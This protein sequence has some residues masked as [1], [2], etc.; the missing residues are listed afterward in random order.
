ML[1]LSYKNSQAELDGAKIKKSEN[2]EIIFLE[3]KKNIK[4]LFLNTFRI[5]SLA[6]KFKPDVVHFQE[7]PHEY[8][9]AAIILLRKLPIVLTVHDPVPHIGEDT[10]SHNSFWRRKDFYSK[11]QRKLA[12]ALISH[13]E[14]LCDQLKSATQGQKKICNIHHGPLGLLFDEVDQP[15]K[16]D[17]F[18]F[19]FFGR[20]QKYKGIELFTKA[21][22]LLKSED[23]N[24]KGVLAGR[25]PELTKI[26]NSIATKPHFI[27][28]DYFLSPKEVA[29]TFDE[30]DVVVLPYIEG[31]QSGVAA[32]AIGRGKPCIISGVGS[33]PE[34][35]VDRQTGIIIKPN[36]IDELVDAM[37]LLYNERKKCIEMGL[38][39]KQLGESEKS[40]IAAAEKT[41]KLY[42]SIINAKN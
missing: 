30:S 3:H 16:F 15:Q 7:V 14:F 40:W 10:Q 22:E 33:L 1:V 39:A 5:Y 34:M 21:I 28:K 9:T 11:L 13:G 23:L 38:K 32:L 35:V 6:R 18:N 37:R 29:T 12:G 17:T 25:G 41:A 36:N 8:Q 4:T 42:E 31:T 20:M 26:K 24:I 2:L 27:T 19:L